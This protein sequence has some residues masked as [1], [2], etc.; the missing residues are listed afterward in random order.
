[1]TDVDYAITRLTE[2]WSD[3]LS[4]Q[5]TGRDRYITLD[6]KPMLDMLDDACRSGIGGQPSSGRTDP[7]GR[8]LLDLQAFELREHIDGTVRAWIGKLGREKP[9]AELKDAV[10]QLSGILHAHHA[11]GTIPDSEHDRIRAFFPRWCEKISRIY[12]PPVEKELD[13]ACPNAECEQTHWV[14]RD[15]DQAAALIAFYH[16]GSGLVQAKCRACGWTWGPDA[17]RLLGKHLGASQDEAV[18][19][20]AG[21]T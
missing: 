18:I 8:S 11:A 4:P 14:N 6:Y 13:G 12:D 10:R 20:A 7:A 16:R 1:M 15:G 2:P 5:E 17:V 3:V 19:E 21:L 9:A